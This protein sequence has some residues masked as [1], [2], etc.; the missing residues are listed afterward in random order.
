MQTQRAYQP[1]AVDA[2]RRAARRIGCVQQTRLSDAVGQRISLDTVM[3]FR[4]LIPPS[5]NTDMPG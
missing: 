1:R 3:P 2:D 4:G 5:T